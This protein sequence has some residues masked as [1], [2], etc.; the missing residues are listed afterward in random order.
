MEIVFDCTKDLH[1]INKTNVESMGSI[2]LGKQLR[3]ANEVTSALAPNE[4][5]EK[6]RQ[7]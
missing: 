2:N 1:P 6:K 7:N 5:R 4:K 3:R